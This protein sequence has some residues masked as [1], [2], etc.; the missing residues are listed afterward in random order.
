MEQRLSGLAERIASLEA[1]NNAIREATET[2]REAAEER[3]K[4]QDEMLEL[5]Y[6]LKSK[7]DKW[8]GKFGG[9]LFAVGCLWAFF[10]N[11]GQAVWNWIITHGVPGKS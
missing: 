1:H 7:I 10:T 9:V 4:K 2:L 5:L 3:A 8:E 11:F 6:T